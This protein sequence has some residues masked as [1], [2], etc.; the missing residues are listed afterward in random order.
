[1]VIIAT[2]P[3][4]AVLGY[5]CNPEGRKIKD[6]I[7]FACNNAVFSSLGR[8]TPII[9]SGG[10]TDPNNF[11]GISEAMMMEKIAREEIGCVNPMYREEESITTI[12][13]IR[14][15]KKLWIEHRYDKDS[16]AILS[17]K[18]ECIICD[19]DRA[20]KVSYIARCIFREDIS[21]KGFD[22]GRTKKEKIF[23]VAGNIKDIISI[24]SP[25]I[26]EIFLNQRRREI[27]LTN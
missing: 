25:K 27:T 19:K 5:G 8:E 23:V 12:Q 21:I 18:P 11:P 24:H 9:F 22:F 14:N 10:F 1:V 6:Y 4:V 2:R 20:Q 26:E 17:E 3:Y 16:V 15:I 13:N 7:Y